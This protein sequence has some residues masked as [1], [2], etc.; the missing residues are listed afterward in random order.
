MLSMNRVGL[1]L[2]AALVLN[3][4]GSAQAQDAPPTE[5]P[6]TCTPRFFD[7]PIDY[8]QRGIAY[9]DGKTADQGRDSRPNQKSDP[10]TASSDWGQAIRLPDGTVAYQ[11]LPKLL[12]RVLEEP[13]PDNIRTYF[14]WRMTRAQK[15]LRAAELM[16]EYR[17][18]SGPKT[19]IVAEGARSIPDLREPLEVIAPQEPRTA[20]ALP[21]APD[22]KRGFVVT[23][24]NKQGCPH[25]DTQDRILAE[26]LKENPEGRLDTVEFGTRPELWK[27]YRVRGTPSLVVEDSQ[28]KK[29]I[30]LE[31]LSRSDSLNAALRACRSAVNTQP[32]TEEK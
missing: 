9:S 19:P 5:K 30:F 26:W 7:R 6:Q 22:A 15:I 27:A 28:S 25:C 18:S 29:A 8:W 16:K 17:S 23:Y 24:F 4:L 32:T 31:G 11:D 13:T 10:S 21:A 3:V 20:A 14:E 2:S 12:V 1:C